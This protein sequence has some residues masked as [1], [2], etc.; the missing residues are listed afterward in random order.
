L[1][2]FTVLD[3]KRIL[4]VIAGGIAAY[5]SLELIRRL[6][7][8]GTEVR[9]VLTRAGAEFVTPLTVSTLAEQRVYTDLFEI[10]EGGAIGHIQLAREADLVVVAPA[11]ADL[12]AKMATGLAD[13]LAST[14]LLATQGPVLIA[15]AMHSEMWHHPA[16]RRNLARLEADGVRRVGPATGELASGDVGEGRM[17]EPHEILEAIEAVLSATPGLGRVLAGRRAIVTSGPTFEAIDPVRF[18]GNR[19]SGKQGHAIA[20]ALARLG[21]DT[22]LVSGPSHEPDP[23][24]VEVIRIESA[25]QMLEACQSQLPVDVAVCA[26]AVSDWRVAS[27]NGKKMKKNGNGAPK[28]ELV[29][30]PDILATLSGD[31][32]A[33]PALV[34]G[35]AAETHDLLAYA[36]EKRTR[37][38][39]DWIV[40]ND[41]SAHVGTFGSDVNKVHLLTAD[42]AEDWPEQTK[43][44][45]AEHLARRIAEH[46]NGTAGPA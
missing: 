10:E 18:I 29:E 25:R 22:V 23:A 26:A 9:C 41:V 2:G 42:G 7:E 32:K 5:K 13:D 16:T 35:F 11:T 40:A 46:F 34:V 44:E 21:A 36:A 1:V 37:K 4:L 33:R 6:R 8:R 3:G 43:V 14:A 30:N 24:D 39:C 17:A 45:V 38:G 12:M 27:E 19:S 28:L 31:N 15:P 20:G